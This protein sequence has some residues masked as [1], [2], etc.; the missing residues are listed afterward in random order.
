M[1]ITVDLSCRPSI[2]RISNL[3]I[4]N[5]LLQ[6]SISNLKEKLE[7][8]TISNAGSGE[9]NK[10]C[11]ITN[12]IIPISS[13]STTLHTIV[14]PQVHRTFSP[15][16]GSFY[17]GLTSAAFDEGDIEPSTRHKPPDDSIVPYEWVKRQ[18]VAESVKQRQLETVN[19]LTEKLDF[20]QVEPELGMHLLSIYWNRQQSLGPVVYRT[21]FMRDMACGGRHF[22]KLLLNA[23]YFYASKYTKR[24]EVC[25][26]P[27]NRL[28]AGWVYRRRVIELLNASYGASNITTIQALLLMSTAIFAWC[29][30]KSISWLYAGMAFNM[31]IDLGMHVDTATMKRQFS[32]EDV[33][34]RIRVFWSAFSKYFLIFHLSPSLLTPSL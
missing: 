5:R 21:A 26:D 17:H 7:S 4:E 2:A 28:T 8:V 1:S 18:L 10:T 13:P 3:E 30:E 27:T 32:A 22:S 11:H 9:A 20:D 14:A 33:E 12:P 16:Q 24:V 29:D 31:I 19:F 23:I 6:E 25:Q 15:D 34:I